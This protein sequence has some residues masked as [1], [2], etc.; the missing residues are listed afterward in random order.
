VTLDTRSPPRTAFSGDQLVELD[1]P[2]G[3]RVCLVAG[4][5]DMRKGLDSLAVQA[6]ARSGSVSRVMCFA[7]GVAEAI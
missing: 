4:A 1:L 3:T 6:Q 7:F 5:T 2:A